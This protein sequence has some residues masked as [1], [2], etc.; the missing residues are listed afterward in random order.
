M[1]QDLRTDK[2]MTL[3][4]CE[5]RS[6]S[7]LAI[8]LLLVIALDA[9]AAG[10]AEDTFAA[11][12]LACKDIPDAARRLQCFDRLAAGVG[13]GNSAGMTSAEDEAG[14]KALPALGAEVGKPRSEDEPAEEYAGRVTSC[15]KSDVSGR[16]FFTFDNGQVW[17]QSNKGRLPFR[18]CEFS[19]TLKRDL[20]GYKLEI[21]SENRTVRVTRVK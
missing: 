19:V 1:R 21:P 7:P 5:Q 8:A 2:S 12:L 14:A 15:E 13:E 11:G 18:E 17:R 16:W 4:T 10:A 3:N 6:A 20:F 9:G